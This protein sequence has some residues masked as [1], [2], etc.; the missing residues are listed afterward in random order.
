MPSGLTG[1]ETFQLL[2]KV[3]D[4]RA[5]AQGAI[6]ENL[7]NQDTPGYEARRVEFQDALKGAL[8]AEGTLRPAATQPGHFG[9]AGPD[10]IRRVRGTES[11]VQGGAGPDGNTVAPE[12]EMA[13]MAENSVMFDAAAQIIA[14]KYRDLKYVIREGR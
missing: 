1:G 7:A 9:A 3:L 8:G 13:R 5:Q 11:V 6:A 14:S 12:E 2:S 10:A 4:L